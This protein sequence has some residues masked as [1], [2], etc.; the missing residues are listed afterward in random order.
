[1]YFDPQDFFYFYS[2][3]LWPYCAILCWQNF[4]ASSENKFVPI[5]ER[6]MTLKG[7]LGK[8]SL[9][10]LLSTISI[11]W[12]IFGVLKTQNSTLCIYVLKGPWFSWFWPS[13]SSL[14]WRGTAASAHF[15]KTQKAIRVWR[16]EKWTVLAKK[17]KEQHSCPKESRGKKAPRKSG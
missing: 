2:D 13:Y 9:P 3:W 1:M 17:N 7:H 10:D 8:T 4:T 14:F 6:K 12:N 5:L 16:N 15:E 11:L